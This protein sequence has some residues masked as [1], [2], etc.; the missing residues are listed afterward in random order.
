ML[1]ET[2]SALSSSKTDKC[3]YATGEEILPSNQSLW[4]TKKTFED[5]REKQ[6]KAL[7]TLKSDNER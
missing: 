5:Q 1:I 3:E 4:K 2:V 6:Y 7:E